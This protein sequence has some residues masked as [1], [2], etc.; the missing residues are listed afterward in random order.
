MILIP[1]QINEQ[2]FNIFCALQ[3][4]NIE[5]IREYDPAQ[6]EPY[7]LGAGW[8]KLKL[9]IVFIGYANNRDIQRIQA[10][11]AVGQ[12]DEALKHLSH[13]FQFKPEAGDHDKL[14]QSMKEKK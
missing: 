6:I 2:E 8:D 13:G 1:F 9:N 3:Q 10:W 14:Y 12:L 7:K 11:I 5:R 4:E